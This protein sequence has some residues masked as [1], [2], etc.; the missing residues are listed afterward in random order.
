MVLRYIEDNGPYRVLAFL[1]STLNLKPFTLI[2]ATTREGLLSAPLRGRFGLFFH[3]D[4][5]SEE[6]LSSVISRS[7]KM[8]DVEIDKE[9]CLEIAKRARG[10]PRLANRLLRRVRDYSQVKARG[11]I[12]LPIVEKALSFLRIDEKGLD[13]LDRKYLRVLIEIYK[14]GPAGIEAL[15]ATL[16]EEQDTLIALMTIQG[17][18][19]LL[20]KSQDFIRNSFRTIHNR[21]KSLE[22]SQKILNDNFENFKKQRMRNEQFFI[23]TV[24]N[25]KGD[26]DELRRV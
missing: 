24:V 2:G 13:E 26:I 14:G 11:S 23:D 7:A 5:Y 15:S 4:F 25:L 8:L 21:L 9:S 16:G 22:D 3:F 17:S 19:D 6:D 12:K 18:I 10:T 20:T 1:P